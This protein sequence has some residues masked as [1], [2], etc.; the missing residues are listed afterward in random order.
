LL[1]TL[2]IIVDRLVSDGGGG[3]GGMILGRT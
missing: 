3:S 1:V 2:W